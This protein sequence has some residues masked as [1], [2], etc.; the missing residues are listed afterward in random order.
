MIKQIIATTALIAI[1]ATS[2]QASAL[3]GTYFGAQIGYMNSKFTT[4]VTPTGGTA[5]K[6]P[7]KALNVFP[8][9]GFHAGYAHVLDNNIYLAG[10]ASL[11]LAFK[12]KKTAG[13]KVKNTFF[14]PTV[15]GHV[16]YA[17]NDNVAAYTGL[18][19]GFNHTA[20]KSGATQSLKAT[21]LAMGPLAAIRYNEGNYTF[22]L[23]YAF[24]HSFHNTVKTTTSTTRSTVNDHSVTIKAA[25]KI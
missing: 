16:G 3:S 25:Y 17:F 8:K 7:T 12:S 21:R 1:A 6:T 19:M 20:T 15:A 24:Q 10:E 4:K 23:Q 11:N 14:N 2:A 22:V 18:S 9:F 5:A 13:T